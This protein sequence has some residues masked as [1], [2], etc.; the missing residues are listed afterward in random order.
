MLF[1]SIRFFLQEG[2]LFFLKNFFA[3]LLMLFQ[4]LW[5]LLCLLFYFAPAKP[6]Q[7]AV[8]SVQNVN[9][10]GFDI[11]H[12]PLQKQTYFLCRN[13]LLYRNTSKKR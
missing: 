6:Q 2:L 13:H 12:E 7:Q 5:L 3:Q 11:L 10:P 9:F 4:Q 8:A 1:F